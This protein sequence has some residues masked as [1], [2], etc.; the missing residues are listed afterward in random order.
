MNRDLNNSISSAVTIAP[1]ANR[2]ADTNGSGVDLA[3]YRSAVAIVQF[4]TVTDGTWTPKLE[5]SDSSGSGYSD[6][7]ASDLSGSFTATTSSNDET[8]Q[9]V[10]YL[11]SKRY[12]RVS[13][14]ETVASSTGALFNAVIVRGDPITK[15]A[16]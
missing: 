15:P 3:G 14:I 11:G 2:T 8:T 1:A 4:G 13:V 6:V 16:S 5:E 12:I 10:A 7:A 9:E